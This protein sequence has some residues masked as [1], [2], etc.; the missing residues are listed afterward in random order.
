MGWNH[1]LD[2]VLLQEIMVCSAWQHYDD[3]GPVWQLLYDDAAP[4]ACSK[5]SFGLLLLLGDP[6]PRFIIENIDD[7]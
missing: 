5:S 3:C 6:P 1:Q 2:M 7:I 4:L